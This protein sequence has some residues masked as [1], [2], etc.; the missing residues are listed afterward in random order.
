M[1]PQ[2]LDRGDLR[3]QYDVLIFVTQTIPESD[4]AEGSGFE[5][6]GSAP[7]NI[8]AEYQDRL[9]A[10]T[11]A[12]T[13]PR[14]LEFLEAGGTIV[15]VGT[16]TALARLAGLPLSNHL[17]D[18]EG[19]ALGED[20]FYVPGSVLRVRVDPPGRIAWGLG[21]ELD[22]FFDNSPVMRLDPAA[23]GMGVHPVAW[24]DSTAPLRSGWA[25]GQ[26]RLRGGV[27]MAEARVGRGQPLPLRAR[28]HQP[29][30]AARDLQ[31]AL[32]RHLPRR[33][34]GPHG[35]PDLVTHRSRSPATCAPGA[36]R[37]GS[38]PL[39][40]EVDDFDVR[41]AVVLGAMPPWCGTRW[42]TPPCHPARAG[43]HG[44]AAVVVGYSHGDWDHVWGSAGLPEPREVVAHAACAPRFV[45]ELPAELD[46]RRRAEPGRWEE[47]ALVP[48]DRVF[49]GA[50]ALDLGGCPCSWRRFPATRPTA[51]WRGFPPG[52]CSSRATPWRRPSPW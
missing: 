37:P 52:G 19:R 16:S 23:V 29:G 8:P 5:I 11:V 31:A 32:Q 24:F 50:V 44:G 36:L 15:T 9:G 43:G 2:E 25:W 46:A 4:G 26:E 13:V 7:E 51:P 27:A 14:L 40:P 34:E 22:V 1:Y 20:Q 21:E 30:A 48:P 38:P 18:G 33:G 28:D 41:A 35:T 47:V 49:E 12:K 42:R 3:N 10:I 6:F 45:A 39:S 17:V